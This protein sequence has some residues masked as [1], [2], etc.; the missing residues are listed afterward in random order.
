MGR[1]SIVELSIIFTI[2]VL[3]VYGPAIHD[4]LGLRNLSARRGS[5]IFIGLG[6]VVAFLVTFLILTQS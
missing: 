2:V 5:D 3:L 6:I 4:R 1:L